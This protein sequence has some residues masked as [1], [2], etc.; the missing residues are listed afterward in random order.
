M[1]MTL[2]THTRTLPAISS[3]R[4][5]VVL[6]LAA[7]LALMLP[8][9]AASPAQL[10]SDESLYLAEAYNI[11]HGDGATYPSGDAV[12]HRAPLF[13]ALLAPAVRISGPDGAYL[14][15]KVIVAVNAALVLALGWR[16]GG[17]IAGASAGFVA[18]ASSYLREFGTT[19][20]LDPAQ[21]TALL[22]VL[23]CLHAAT[24]GNTVRWMAAAG[25][26]GGVAF[27]MKESAIQWAPLGVIAW[28][29]LPTLRTR[30]GARGALVYC[31]A[32]VVVIAWWP[33]Y[34]WRETGQ[35]YLLGSSPRDAILLLG[36]AALATGVFA[37]GIARWHRFDRGARSTLRRLATPGAVL[38][39][40]AWSAVLLYGLTTHSTWGYPND[41]AST[42]P[43]YLWN[44]GSAAQPFFLLMAAWAWCGI[45][46]VRGDERQRI[47]AIGAT[48]FAPFAIFAANRGLQLRD[49][50]PLM[51]LSYVALGLAIG[52]AVG[53]ARSRAGY[54]AAFAA[55]CAIAAL[56]VA[57]AV[58]Q[59]RQFT[60]T[61]VEA[62]AASRQ[63]RADSWDNPLV[64][65]LAGWMRANVPPGTNVL[66]SRVYFSSLHVQTEGAYEIRQI[67]TVRVDITPDNDLLL[68]PASNLFRWGDSDL[69]DAATGDQWLYLKQYPGKGYW[70]ALSQQELLDY[71][72][73]NESEILVLSG[74]DIAFSS[75]AYASYF[76]T[77][78]A[79]E[80][81]TAIRADASNQA[82]VFRIH[83]SRLQ[84]ITYST[85]IGP[86]SLGA[87]M[88]ESGL[89]RPEIERRLG[90]RLRVTDR[91]YGLSD[92]EQW[93]ALAGTE[94]ESGP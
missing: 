68:T 69:R 64:A 20:Y 1:A 14:V 60:Q 72:G 91:D 46:A 43:R 30:A 28:L 12:T 87:L 94:G 85:V 66:S 34:V 74:D 90:T 47:I 4:L 15:A 51:Y 54:N 65:E 2:A 33:V 32:F 40:L 42:L 58:Q 52:H 79:F 35:P 55:S 18:A 45:A 61:T 89:T 44:V 57:L 86:S 16:L 10:T 17:A 84:P 93:A 13:P 31:S 62:G 77:N 73:A 22:V 48:L 6:S 92:G 24:R 80:L 82:F 23:L 11:A 83:R 8:M 41:Y 71:I 50:L 75:V 67:P 21:S 49:A 39:T 63:V 7:I 19:L 76:A 88:R 9:F 59:T 26:M 37:V 56:G 78:P 70:V 25:A 27:L 36:A 29:A 3:S 38:V 53:W 5:A 81:L